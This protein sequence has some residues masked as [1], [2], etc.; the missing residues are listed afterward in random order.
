[1]RILHIITR[2]I[3]GG[4]Q[5]NT[6]LC[7]EDQV[8]R[9]HQVWLAFGPIYGPE[10]SMRDAGETSGAELIEVNAM[11][12]AVLPGHDYLCYRALRRLIR[13][14][15]PEVVHTHSSK[16]GILGRAAAWAQRVPAVV[17]TVHGLP[18]HE[19]QPW[20]VHRAYVALERW[21]ARRCHHLIAITPAMVEAFA[22]HRIAP[23]DRFTVIPSGVVL[24]DWQ[25]HSM[26]RGHVRRE[27]GMPP[28]APL[29]A[30]VARLDPLKGHDDLLDVLP[31]LGRQFPQLRA[32]FIGDGWHRKALELRIAR[33][34][35]GDRALITGLLPQPEVARLLSACDVKVLP[36]Y[37]E[38][39]SRTLV[40]ALLCGCG[41]VGYDVG[42]IGAIIDDGRTGRL[43]PV[44]DRP[45]L[46]EA[47]AWMIEHPQDRARLVAQGQAHVRERFDARSMVSRV[48][49]VYIDALAGRYGKRP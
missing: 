32:L 11:R 36:S 16:A 3:V 2:L 5:Q 8:A 47:I 1:M 14:I 48:M 18:F 33:E 31:Q 44:G 49:D 7:C 22:A 34:G 10:G 43:V 38:G 15:E 9:G 27:L 40:E 13:R 20:H 4:A 28:D 30:L 39:Q 37:Q 24:D 42:G 12:R 35:L 19:R 41:V 46:A 17:H 45:R 23:A 29:L 25:H 6:V 26:Q 21:A